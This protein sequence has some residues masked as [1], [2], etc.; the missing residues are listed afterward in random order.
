MIMNTTYLLAQVTKQSTGLEDLPDGIN[1]RFVQNGFRIAFG[2][3]GGIALL[4]VAYGGLKYTLS[5]GDP[6]EINKAKNTIVDALIGLAVIVTAGGIIS[7]V[8]FALA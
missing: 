7:F 3:A 4:V 6:Q 1:D 5:Q 8:L 2:I